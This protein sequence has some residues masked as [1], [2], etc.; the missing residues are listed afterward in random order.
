MKQARVSRG[1]LLQSLGI[2]R[3]AC[4][5]FF[6]GCTAS[7]CVGL[8]IYSTVISNNVMLYALALYTFVAHVLFH[9]GEFLVAASSRPHDTCAESFM[10][11]H[12]TAYVI[13]SLLAYIECFLRYALPPFIVSPIQPQ[14]WSCS[15]F[16]LLTLIFYAIRLIGMHQCGSHFSL[17]IEEVRREEH[18]L[19]TTGVYAWCRHPAYFGWFWRTVFAQLILGNFFCFILHSALTW[20]FFKHRIPYEEHLLEKEEFFGQQYV[21]YKSRTYIGIPF[22]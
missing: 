18:H 9:M 12:S 14:F 5:A 3:I 10:I 8:M 11:F 1:L 15:L 21:A 22:I 13:A 6:L 16:A 2:S 7:I 17:Q 19:V 4:I 20:Y